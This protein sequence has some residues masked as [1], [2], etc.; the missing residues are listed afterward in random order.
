MLFDKGTKELI[1]FLLFLLIFNDFSPMHMHDDVFIKS[2]LFIQCLTVARCN[3]SSSHLFTTIDMQV[4]SI[5][6]KGRENEGATRSCKDQLHWLLRSYKCY[7]GRLKY[8]QSSLFFSF[9]RKIQARKIHIVLTLV[10]LIPQKA[11]TFTDA[12]FFIYIF[13]LL[14]L[15]FYD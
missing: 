9:S 1:F 15:F 5:E 2:Q 7:P 6:W 8:N 4:S 10:R 11:A 13:L 12:T 3:L 14:L